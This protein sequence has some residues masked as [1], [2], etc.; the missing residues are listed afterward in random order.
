MSELV[1]STTA[2]LLHYLTHSAIALPLVAAAA[3]LGDRFVR[4]VGPAAQHKVWVFALLCSVA[5][6][7][8]PAGLMHL[9]WDSGVSA[10]AS[11]NSSLAMQSMPLRER[12]SLPSA[13]CTG[14]A[15][16]Y[17]LAIVFSVARLLWRWQR[18]RRFADMSPEFLQDETASILLDDAARRLGVIT[19]EVR[20]CSVL[21]SPVV[22]GVR[23][24]VLLLPADFLKSTAAHDVAAALAH[25]CAHIHRRDFAK[26]LAYECVAAM[27]AY[28]PIC[29]WMRRR[30]AQTRELVCDEMAAGVVASRNS[31]AASLLRLATSMAN[32]VAAAPLNAIGIFDTNSLNTNALEERIMRLTTD[33][34]KLSN[35]R[36]TLLTATAACALLGGAVTATATGFD[37]S[38]QSGNLQSK[39]TIYHVGPGVTPPVLVYAIDA[40]FT[41]KARHAKYQGVSVVSLIVDTQGMPQH[42]QT[43]RRLGMGL[44]EKA[45]EAVRQYRFK[46]SMHNGEAVPVSIT[47][48]VNFRIY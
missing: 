42:I 9:P 38:P 24:S 29:W 46:P 8:L 4:R 34:P 39:E 14:L 41:N 27:V 22:L 30:I 5:L 12:F 28:H 23:R 47:I 20:S 16:L 1:Q 7:L 25:E 18:T 43:T 2:F 32:R 36:K 26:N 13:I 35:V 15:A 19:P 45:I 44:D 40:Q 6:P 11:A 10:T 21:N 37:V 3:W 17:L 48:E 31:Y 33:R